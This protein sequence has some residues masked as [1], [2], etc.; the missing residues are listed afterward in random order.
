MGMNDRHRRGPDSL[1][2]LRMH[3]SGGFTLLEVLI[4][5]AIFA[6]CAAVLLTQS[7]RALRQQQV[8][9]DRTLAR[10]VAE[11][12]LTELQL[13]GEWQPMGAA[14]TRARMAQRRWKVETRIEATADPDL[15]RVEIAVSRMGVDAPVLS[16]LSGFLGRH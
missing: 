16:R 15:E 4:A 10:W 1:Y 14:D 5:L 7:G 6:L 8:L 13:R 3:R 2:R 11:N 9:E 12:Q